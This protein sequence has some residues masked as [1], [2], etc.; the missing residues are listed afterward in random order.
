MYTSTTGPAS[1]LSQNYKNILY[2]SYRR[3]STTPYTG[4]VQVAFSG[5]GIYGFGTSSLKGESI[6]FCSKLSKFLWTYFSHF[7]LIHKHCCM[8]RKLLNPGA[9]LPDPHLVA[10]F[11]YQGLWP[12]IPPI[13]CGLAFHV[14]FVQT[15]F[16]NFWSYSLS[17]L[18]IL[19]I[20]E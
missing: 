10:V 8:N 4:T 14:A 7:W 12:C 13:R 11:T 17:A 2:S 5:G 15:N 9:P 19:C 18:I 6:V 1:Y 20:S 16:L 3:K